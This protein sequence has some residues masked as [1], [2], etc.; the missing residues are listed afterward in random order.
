[1]A[2]PQP[3]TPPASISGSSA[4]APSP[5]MM[6]APGPG[7][8]N[9]LPM[10]GASSYHIRFSPV[11]LDYDEGKNNFPEP[12]YQVTTTTFKNSIWNQAHYCNP[13]FQPEEW[14]PGDEHTD[15]RVGSKRK[16]KKE[17]S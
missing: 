10:R 1:M 8:Q 13:N 11:Q 2:S 16:P 17:S 12:T 6:A 4:M 9:S 14:N 7:A 15:G 5:A 3:P